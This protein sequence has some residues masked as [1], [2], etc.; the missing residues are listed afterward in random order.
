MRKEKLPFP[1]QAEL[2]NLIREL[3]EAS[4][5]IAKNAAVMYD[6]PAKLLLAMLQ[7][8]NLHRQIITICKEDW[9]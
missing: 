2:D 9:K 1:A 3:E 8:L 7:V 5:R 6:D 4:Y